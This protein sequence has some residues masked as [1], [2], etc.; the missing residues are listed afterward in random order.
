ML[1]NIQ[2]NCY[3]L[4]TTTTT[5]NDNNNSKDKGLTLSFLQTKPDNLQIVDPDKIACN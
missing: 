3:Y 1:K 5:T 4:L 2:M